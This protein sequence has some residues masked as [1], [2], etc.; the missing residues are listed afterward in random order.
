MFFRNVTKQSIKI[1]Y[2]KSFSNLTQYYNY[3]KMNL[4][5]IK[6]SE[7]SLSPTSS[8]S[9][10]SPSPLKKSFTTTGIKVNK[11][12]RISSN[13]SSDD[14]INNKEEITQKS[15]PKKKNSLSKSPVKIECNSLIKTDAA[16][17]IQNN[18]KANEEEQ[19]EKV[20][21][22]KTETGGNADITPKKEKESV[23]MNNFFTNKKEMKIQT[24]GQGHKGSDYNPAKTNY[25]PIKDAFWEH[26]EK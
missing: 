18:V 16:A 19:Q 15:H 26:N 13:T 21:T 24:V 9:S 25:D 5:L 4:K 8:A 12:R 17:E 3:N 1:L 22:M 14:E 23:N 6:I 20:D 10:T 2:S 11:R 7:R